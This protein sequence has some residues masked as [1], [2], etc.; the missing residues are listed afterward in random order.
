M[1]EEGRRRVIGGVEEEMSN[2]A[3][4]QEASAAASS[5]LGATLLRVAWLAILLGM[6][7]E[8]TLLLLSAGFGN[9][10]S[11]GSIVADLAKNVSWAVWSASVFQLER[12]SAMPACR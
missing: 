7:M 6:A 9:L 4:A 11:L 10:L 5:N 8:G 2:D 12:P 3:P 1:S